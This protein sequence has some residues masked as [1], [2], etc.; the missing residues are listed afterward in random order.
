MDWVKPKHRARQLKKSDTPE[1]EVSASKW[2]QQLCA[3]NVALLQSSLPVRESQAK[4][5]AS[6]V[7]AEE[8]LSAM[9]WGAGVW[10]IE[11]IHHQEF[12][13]DLVES[14]GGDA[15]SAVSSRTKTK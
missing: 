2:L 1:A 7:P 8:Y 4:Q 10:E 15:S 5:R 12:L 14:F 6:K 3:E 13:N 11:N 9:L